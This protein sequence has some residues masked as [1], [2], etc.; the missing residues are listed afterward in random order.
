[1]SDRSQELGTAAVLPPKGPGD[2]PRTA[3]QAGPPPRRR[4]IPA[5][6]VAVAIVAVVALAAWL[7]WL[8][9]RPAQTAPTASPVPSASVTQSA[10]VGTTAPVETTA[11]IVV[12]TPPAPTP[13]TVRQPALV[14]GITG[15]D[16]T[17]YKITVD[18]VQV[19]TGKAA[20]DAAAAAGQESPPPNDYFIE[21]SSKQLRTFDV[22]KGASVTVLGWAGAGATT[23]KKITVAQFMDVM[24]G[25]AHT[26]DEWT[27]SYYRVT[28]KSG[29]TVTTIEQ[30][31]FP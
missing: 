6:V 20:A 7:V 15:N 21:N 2:K 8:V 3:T 11:P 5:W 10:T 1:M 18:Y 30:I 17:G 14:T 24:P 25:G 12:T 19:L 9:M 27:Q 22:P 28:V 31:F 26:K 29:T 23:K 16:S 13:A 4:G